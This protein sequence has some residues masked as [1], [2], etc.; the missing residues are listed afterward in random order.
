MTDET[1][2]STS[3][4]G[5]PEPGDTEPE[6]TLP[7]ARRALRR[8]AEGAV[9]VAVDVADTV[10]ST[11]ARIIDL[12]EPVVRRIRPTMT[13]ALQQWRNREAA[14]LRRLRSLNREPLPNLYELHPEARVAS[15]H[16]LGLM[17]VPVDD[18]RGTAVDGYAQ[19]GRDYLPLKP[20]RSSNW[21]G[22]WQ[23]IR[24]AVETLHALPPI[25][26]LRTEEGYWV[27]DGHNRVAAALYAGQVAMDAVVTAVLLPGERL[28]AT[29]GSLAP[30]A[31]QSDEVR[32]AARG[33][34][35]AGSSIQSQAH[36]P[37]HDPHGA[38]DP[39]SPDEP[40]RDPVGSGTHDA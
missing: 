6:G 11:P 8:A 24:T 14:R 10:A 22:R 36:G 31:Q 28:D 25:E 4:P 34:L 3:E 35:T 16:E 21:A 33:K 7:L 12:T 2:R 40:G 30:V 1:P 26:L 13:A 20:Y 17:T 27:V 32:A 9:D 5:P 15:T 37:V 29:A 38:G 23:R 19:R 39:A 18:I